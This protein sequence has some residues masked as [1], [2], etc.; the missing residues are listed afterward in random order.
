MEAE[1]SLHPMI[2]LILVVYIGITLI[3]FGIFGWMIWKDRKSEKETRKET[4][5]MIRA[6][7]A[8]IDQDADPRIRK[9]MNP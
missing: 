9:L 3:T 2:L 8:L 5:R 6:F 7:E 1:M 4:D